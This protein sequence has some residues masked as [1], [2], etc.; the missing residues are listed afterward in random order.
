MNTI[1]NNLHT[2]QYF[3]AVPYATVL[4]KRSDHF[5]IVGKEG[6]ADD[7]MFLELHN[8]HPVELIDESMLPEIDYKSVI[9]AWNWVEIE[10]KMKTTVIDND[11]GDPYYSCW[12]GSTFGVMPSGKIYAV[13][14]SNQTPEDVNRDQQ[15]IEALDSVLGTKGMFADW[16][17]GDLCVCK[18]TTYEEVAKA[19]GFYLSEY[20]GQYSWYEMADRT[21]SSVPFETEDEAWEDCCDINKLME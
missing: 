7:S 2:G 5:V 15:F 16:D 21:N 14:T 9:L 20:C 4:V 1:Y 11:S 3:F 17:N 18:M 10:K 6:L 12:I 13:W 8:D 19:A